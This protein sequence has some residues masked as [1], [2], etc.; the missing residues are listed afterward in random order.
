M[1]KLLAGL[2]VATVSIVLSVSVHAATSYQINASASVDIDEY[3]TCRTVTNSNAKKMM[4]AT[5][6]STAWNN[7][8]THVPPNV[9]AVSCTSCPTG[10]VRV[11]GDAT[12]STSDFCVM[13]YEAKNVG[14]VATSQSALT[15]WVNVDY[16]TA[17]SKCTALGTGYDIISNPE[18]QTI[19]TNLEYVD[20][21]WTGGSRGVGMLKIGAV[22]A[23]SSGSYKPSS[24]PEAGVTNSLA[25]Q[26]LSN[27]KTI[28]HMG[29]NVNEWVLAD[30]YTRS[31]QQF[32]AGASG[33]NVISGADRVKFGPK[34]TYTSGCGAGDDSYY[35]QCGLGVYTL[36]TQT[37]FIRGG[38]C[39]D[40]GNDTFG[41]Y[42]QYGGAITSSTVGFRCVY[43]P[44]PPALTMVQEAETVWNTSTLSKTTASFNVQTGDVLVAYASAENGVNPALTISGGS[45]TWT[46]RQSIHT[47]NSDADVYIW[48]AVANATTAMT[49][50]FTMGS[51]GVQYGGNVLTFRNSGGVGASSSTSA[52][53]GPFLNLT[54]TKANSAIVFVSGD[55]NAVDG[56]TRTYR[57]GA[58]A[59]TEQT[60]VYSS[61][62]YTVYGG[63]YANAGAA[64][65]YAV[66][67]NSPTGQHF[68]IAAIEIKGL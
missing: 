56:S 39:D 59:F 37:V 14:G 30:S 19:A 28:Y 33:A 38:A 47:G 67:V 32:F 16:A 10:Y 11:P 63:Y 43:H 23:N 31:P 49:V 21:N 34:G 57:N 42:L 54:T 68:S 62:R 2:Q 58:G 18:W 51:T 27:G 9:S 52:T 46:L 22:D 1:R 13:Q 20:A 3:G 12:Y 8:L 35:H 64:G 53:G 48:T 24:C 60:Y 29:G 5:N 17:R 25:S 26:V 61:G 65:T 55:W 44:A 4:V 66:G 40:P 50:T 15:P 7:F 6:S 36:V 45:L 41:A